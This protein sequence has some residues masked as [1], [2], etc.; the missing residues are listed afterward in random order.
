MLAEI[1]REG[2][3]WQAVL[4]FP[5]QAPIWAFERSALQRVSETS[6]RPESWQVITPGVKLERIGDFDALVAQ[7][8]ELP[9]QVEVAFIPKATD[10][11]A[12]Y[13]P[14][15]IFSNG[16]LAL[17]SGHFS[18]FPVASRSELETLPRPKDYPARVTMRDVGAQ[19]LHN[20]ERYDNVSLSGSGQYVIFGAVDIVD[21]GGVTTILDPGLPLWL[22]QGMSEFSAVTF[23]YY[24]SRLGDHTEDQPLI[25][26]SWRGPTP[27]MIS[28]GGSVTRN[29]IAMQLEGIGLANPEPRAM[30]R[31]QWFV[32]HEDAHFWLGQTVGYQNRRDMWITEGAADLMAYRLML[33]RDLLP[34]SEIYG[35]VAEARDDCAALLA[36]GGVYSAA[37][38]LEHRAHYACGMVFALAVEQAGAPRG[39]DG[40]D[41]FSIFMERYRGGQIGT[42]EW[43]AA[44]REFGLSESKENLISSLLNEGAQ[45]GEAAMAALLDS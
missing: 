33:T 26:A 16:S 25:L 1:S 3:R 37:E 20:G 18:A 35:M 45:D 15:L 4:S 40:F 22:S 19:V 31:A 24:Q 21:A 41:F 17:Y 10:L 12:D 23:G 28:F 6:W 38:R 9:D 13:D 36:N 5:E 30:E 27:E 32:G 11:L 2:D 39:E 44:A 34:E 8:G 7:S 43:L 42:N 14:A 29:M